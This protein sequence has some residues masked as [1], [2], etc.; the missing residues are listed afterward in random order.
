MAA[1]VEYQY[2][3]RMIVIIWPLLVMVIGALA[4]GFAANPKAAELGRIAFFCGLFWV[5]WL[6]TGSSF[7]LR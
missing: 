7:R 3:S 5:V 6:L 4:Y 1:F 2:H